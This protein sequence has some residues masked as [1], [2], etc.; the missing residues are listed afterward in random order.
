MRSFRLR[1]ALLAGAIAAALL[2]CSGYYAWRLS[3]RFNLDRLDRE[4]RNLGAA[5]LERVVGDEHWRRV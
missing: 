1:L 2:L 5:N 3:V 4:L